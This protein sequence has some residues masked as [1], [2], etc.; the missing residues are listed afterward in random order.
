MAAVIGGSHEL[1]DFIA[2][3]TR[4]K[5]VFNEW[6][7]GK[8]LA[9]P[10]HG[11][12]RRTS[13]VFAAIGDVNATFQALGRL[14]SLVQSKPRPIFRL[15]EIAALMQ[16]AG[17]LANKDKEM[18]LSLLLGT[19]NKRGALERLRLLK[20]ETE[21]SLPRFG[22]VLSNWEQHVREVEKTKTVGLSITAIA[23]IVGY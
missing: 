22:N 9:Y 17:L 13:G 11:I 16:C 18:A 7:Q 20:A 10:S 8:V 12:L 15:I 2:A 3:F 5:L 1:N 19:K 6:V 4:E 14:D 23:A 21:S